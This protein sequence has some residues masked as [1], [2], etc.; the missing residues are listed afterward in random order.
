MNKTLLRC[1]LTVAAMLMVFTTKADNE[2]YYGV[3]QGNGT[4]TDYG[5]G[6][7]ETYDVAL[8][9]TDP[10]LVG[11][12]IRAIR[13]PVN[14]KADNT[15][16]YKAWLT[17]ELSL[18]SGKNVA[19]IVS[20]DVTPEGEWAEA[21]LTEPYIVKE[22]GVYVG[23][24]FKVS[25]VEGENADANKNPMKVIDI[26][27][28]DG[29]LIHTNR[30]FRK[31]TALVEKGTSAL[32][33]CIGGERVKQKAAQLVAPDNLYTMKGKSISTTF[34]LVNHGTESIKN[35]D[36]EIELAGNTVT[37][38]ITKSL[39]GGYYGRFTTI[40]ATIP[41]VETA[42]SYPA[43]LRIT[44]VNG[45]DNEDPQAETVAPV[46]YLSEVPV[47]KPLVEEYTGIW[48]QYCPRALA[49]MEK[50]SDNNGEDFVGIAYH[51]Q[52][53]I[54]FTAGS[55]MPADPAGLPSVFI[56]R[57]SDFN[58]LSGQDSWQKRRDIIA[59]A[60]ISVS[61]EWADSEKTKVRATSA[62]SFIR[63][64]TNNPYLLG[65]V[66]IANDLHSPE[67]KQSNAISGGSI[68][69]DEY[70][71]KYIKSPNPIRDLHYNEV[72]IAQSAT[73]G[74]PLEESLPS[75]VEGGTSYTHE[76][77][78]DITDNT[79]PIDKSKMEVIVILIDTRTG[80]V[81]NCNKCHVVDATG[82]DEVKNSGFGNKVYYDLTGRKVVSPKNGIYVSKG[83]K[84]IK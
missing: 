77:T 70:L 45:E 75:D 65:Y 56:D 22:D 13:I 38:H 17:T 58:P 29:L 68:T 74:N 15:S 48:C 3:Y 73:K 61:A 69:G 31:W 43:K 60:A 24:S 84:I 26:E 32:V 4:L 81:A 11:M 1:F 67:W 33:V 40:S 80:G 30:T 12:E 51:V 46:V 39:A 82:I 8:H 44:K 18:Q 9:L 2:I 37:K 62:T 78:F 83:K 57:V 27:S 64:F 28:E 66:L 63:D 50:M 7:A 34:T 49:G 42:G 23:Y 5:T 71:D 16:E 52:D 25:S 55:Y 35:I 79:I 36:Y 54:S 19:D 53:E 72:A 6:K 47:H 41:A 14:T 20:L 21:R 10:S 76:F 59:P